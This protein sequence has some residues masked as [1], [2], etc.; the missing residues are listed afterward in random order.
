[1][2]NDHSTATIQ[3]D[4]LFRLR[5][6]TDG[7]F[8]PDGRF[9]AYSV[10]WF[11][12]EERREC[13][14]IFLRSMETGQ[15]RQLTTGTAL[16]S[17]PRW[18][19]FG[20]RLAFLSTRNG[21]AQ[22]YLI[23][24]A[25]GEARALTA[26]AQGVGGGIAW[27]PDGAQIA[28]TARPTADEFD[29]TRPY[30]LTRHIVRFD[31]VGYV[32]G[33]VQELWSVAVASGA[34]RQLTRDNAL[35]SAPAWSPDGREI[36]YLSTLRAD[37]HRI[38]PALKVVALDGGSRLLVDDWGYAIAVAW[39]PDGRRLV[40]AG[41][42]AGLPIGAQERLWCIDRTGARPPECRSAAF[43]YKMCGGLQ[44]DMGVRT[45]VRAPRLL[46]AAAGDAA[47]VQVQI[48]G[49]VKLV[50]VAL[51]GPEEC[52]IVASGARSCLLV[53]ASQTHLLMIASTLWDPAQLV[54]VELASGSESTLTTLN[55]DLL[56]TWDQPVVKHLLYPSVDGQL[57]EGWIM[58]PSAGEAPFPTVLY[59]HGGPHS[60]FGHI[61]SFDFRLLCAAGYAVLFINQRA[62]TGYGDAFATQIKGDWGNLDYADLMA[63]VDVAIAQGH[64]DAERLGVCGLSGGGNLS[65]WIVGH[66]DRFKAAVPENPVTNWVSFYG[67]SDIG[68]W[69]AVEQLGGHPHEIP[70]VY[71]RCSPITYAHRCRTPTLLIQ[72]ESDWRCPAEQSEQFYAVLKVNGCPVE[73]LR[74]P[75][76]PHAGSIT[77]PAMLRSAQNEALLEWIKRWV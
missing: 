13:G 69:F 53:D 1:M 11:E 77:G 20:A 15:T 70:E 52:T 21:K 36:A 62:S 37:R 16:D 27:S 47:F 6:V 34:L 46:V 66:T 14:A 60:G 57:V 22:I 23:D 64:A 41:N 50:Q 49:A 24:V 12:G 44:A 43:D 67:V 29:P 17:M 42:P 3:P 58:L 39:T 26:L 33:A 32:D 71:A 48:G 8:S 73:M 76:S 31:E 56:R 63:G 30:R 9:V 68:P 7:Q 10:T 75:A 65:C 4:D 18:S 54:A 61:F 5:L 19:P 51:S 28:F 45:V 72:G 35:A 59:I 74:L 25:G 2:N 38:T 55:S 40:F